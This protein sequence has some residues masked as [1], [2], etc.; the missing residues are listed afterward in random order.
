MKNEPTADS[1]PQ[2]IVYVIDDDRSVRAALEDLLASVGL[3]VRSYS[4]VAEFLESS[5]PDAPGCL[6]L[7][8]RM[9]G[10]SGIDFH[11]QMPEYGIH[12]PTIFITGHGDIT[13][14]VNAIKNGAFEFLTKPFRDQD[15][16]DAIQQAIEKRPA[17]A[18]ERSAFAGFECALG[19]I[20][21]RRTRRFQARCKGPPQ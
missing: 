1:R 19:D 4:S 12:L 6:L 18:R 7:D 2:P 13:M 17:K 9:P 8:V 10:Q 20:D 16:L 3:Q 14:G 15:L 21:A 11:R 5:M